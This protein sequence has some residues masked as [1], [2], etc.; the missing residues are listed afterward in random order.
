MEIWIEGYKCFG[1]FYG[2]NVDVHGW[3]SHPRVTWQNK[4]G[5]EVGGVHRLSLIKPRVHMLLEVLN[6]SPKGEF[7]ICD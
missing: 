7:P 5:D 4:L 3:T 1:V 6:S 2:W